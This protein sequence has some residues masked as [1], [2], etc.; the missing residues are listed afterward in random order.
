MGEITKFNLRVYGLLVNSENEILLVREK[1]GENYF[2]KFPGG[3]LEFGEGIKDCLIR[4]FKEETQI[5]IEVLEHFYTTDFFQPS[6][7]KNSDQIISVYYKVRPLQDT[8]DIR[9]DEFEI[10]HG[11]RTEL[12]QFSWVNLN[13]LKEDML[14]LPI[15]KHVY[16][17]LEAN[18]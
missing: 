7:F 4:E 13:E 10:H 5:D 18:N 3:G 11:S 12:L 9:L 1:I 14:S 17:I 16:R 8:S 2:T 15:D 6:A